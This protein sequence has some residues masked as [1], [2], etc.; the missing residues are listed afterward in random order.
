MAEEYTFPVGD[1]VGFHGVSGLVKV[2]P[3]TNSPD[4]LL[5]LKTVLA[6]LGKNDDR[7]LT[8]T[9]CDLD[10]KMLLFRFDGFVD[11][12]AAEAL[13]GARLFARQSELLPLE[14]EEFWVKDLVG[15]DV[16]TVDGKSVGKICSIVYGGNDL[17]EIT[18]AGDSSGKT[19]LVPFIDS[20]VPVVDFKRRRVEVVDLPG[21]LEPQ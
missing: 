7:V 4:L 11:R 15:L 2:R 8:V 21:L 3:S 17:I 6:R 16:F 20:L 5:E 18:P 12:T 1:I 10:K 14:D 13:A 9:G 19:I